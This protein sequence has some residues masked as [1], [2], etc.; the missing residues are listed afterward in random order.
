MLALCFDAVPAEQDLTALGGSAAWLTY[1][2]MVRTRLWRELTLALSRTFALVGEAA[3]SA[4]F[5]HFLQREPPRTRYFREVVLAFVRSALP[6]WAAD[7]QLDPACCEL[8]RYEL[9]RWEVRDLESAPSDLDVSE[10][11][12]E[13][14]AVVSRA[15]RLL[16]LSHAVHRGAPFERGEFFVCIHRAADTE[17]PKV[18]NLTRTTYQL[19]SSLL[20]EDD[21]VGNVVKKLAQAS[22][23]RIDAAYLDA[24]CATLAQF[25]ENGIILGSR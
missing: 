24:L 18:W 4:A 12:F 7:P 17:R 11:S 3:F 9:A 21:T 13:R 16:A 14:V 19:L 15:L 22:S 6:L 2:E 10:L 20:R 25:L 1:R 8:A 23:T 5:E